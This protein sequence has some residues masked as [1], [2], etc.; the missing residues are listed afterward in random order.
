MQ[1]A[2]HMAVLSFGKVH[3]LPAALNTGDGFP[4]LYIEYPIESKREQ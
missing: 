4:S 2:F 3:F 1:Q